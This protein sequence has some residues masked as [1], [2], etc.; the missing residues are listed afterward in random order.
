[1]SRRFRSGN[2]RSSGHKIFR[3]IIAACRESLEPIAEKKKN[4]SFVSGGRLVNSRSHSPIRRVDRHLDQFFA[5][6][7]RE[8]LDR[9]LGAD[10]ELVDIRLDRD[11]G[12]EAG[13]SRVSPSTSR[14]TQ[15]SGRGKRTA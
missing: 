12:S 9:R 14:H 10:Q 5:D 6:A 4:P 8:L 11:V 13:L 1:M 7:L 3:A 2:L 15:D